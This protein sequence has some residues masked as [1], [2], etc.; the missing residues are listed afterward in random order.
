MRYIVE[1]AII[2]L[3]FNFEHLF[4]NFD[5][6]NEDWSELLLSIIIFLEK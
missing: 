1:L 4:N 6:V 3:L 5:F 2:K